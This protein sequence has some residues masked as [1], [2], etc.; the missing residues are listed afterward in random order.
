MNQGKQESDYYRAFPT[1]SGDDLSATV[2]ETLECVLLE[3]GPEWDQ[4]ESPTQRGDIE[5]RDKDDQRDSYQ[6]RQKQE[7]CRS[8]EVV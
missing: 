8:D 4:Q 1:S 6:R 2:D 7:L 5:T 3:Q